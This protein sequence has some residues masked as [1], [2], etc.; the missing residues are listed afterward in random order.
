MWKLW[1]GQE[2]VQLMHVLLGLW[3]RPP[4]LPLMFCLVTTSLI[5]WKRAKQASTLVYRIRGTTVWSGRGSDIGH[6]R[7]LAQLLK[8][9]PGPFSRWVWIKRFQWFFLESWEPSCKHLAYNLLIPVTTLAYR[10]GRYIWNETKL[11]L[12]IWHAY[13]CSSQKICDCM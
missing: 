13:Q 2:Y 3:I 4:Q 6:A 8:L 12:F 5:W 7:I 9:K 1:G 11:I 10:W